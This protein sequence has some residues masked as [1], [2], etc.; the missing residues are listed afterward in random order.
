MKNAY[1]LQNRTDGVIVRQGR[2][3]VMLTREE[4]KTLIRDLQNHLDNPKRVEENN[5]N[6]RP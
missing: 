3:Y 5:G 6:K 4:I 1:Q 2:S